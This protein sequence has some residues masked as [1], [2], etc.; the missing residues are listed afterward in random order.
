MAVSGTGEPKLALSMMNC[1][2]P[3]GGPKEPKELGELTVIVAVM[4]TD[5]PNT[6]GLGEEVVVNV[7]GMITR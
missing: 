2:D 5:W 6:L 4:V 7:T 3:V 1:T